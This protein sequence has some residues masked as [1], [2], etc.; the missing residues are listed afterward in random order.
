MTVNALLPQHA[1]SSTGFGPCRRADGPGRRPEGPAARCA[2]TRGGRIPRRHH[3]R[4]AR[5]AAGRGPLR[6]VRR[7]APA[8]GGRERGPPRAAG[9][10]CGRCRRR[11]RPEAPGRPLHDPPAGRREEMARGWYRRDGRQRRRRAPRAPRAGR[12]GLAGRAA[13]VEARLRRRRI[14]SRP[15]GNQVSRHPA[16]RWRELHWSILRRS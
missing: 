10:L 1:S 9:D 2:P 12:G 13:A 16:A 8:K 5:P 14:C 7:R 3:L 4:R 11:V 15:R 6:E